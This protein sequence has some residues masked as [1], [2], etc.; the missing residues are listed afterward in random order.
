MP[1]ICSQCHNSVADTATFCDMCGAQFQPVHS[2]G[3][4]AAGA[5][6]NCGMQNLPGELYCDNCGMQL[7]PVVVSPPP[8][9]VQVNNPPPENYNS[10]PGGASP[11]ASAPANVPFPQ[12][13]ANPYASTP[14]N[15][16]YPP[17]G[18]QGGAPNAYSIPP[19]IPPPGPE[20]GAVAPASVPGHFVV[21]GTNAAINFPG[22][23]E[24]LTVGRADPDSHYSPDIDTNP[25]N[26]EALGVS[27]RHARVVAQAGQVYIEDLGSTNFTFVN[28]QRLQPGQRLAIRSGDEVRLGRLVLVYT[29]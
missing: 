11:Y 8:P 2:G 10:A 12:G 24:E 20:Y 28:R 4:A 7:P 23:K 29:V 9:P 5:C 18:V 27:R 17:G 6:P 25:V 21:T 22:G 1:K 13:G 15:P 14:A 3:A 16:P 19:V 26:G